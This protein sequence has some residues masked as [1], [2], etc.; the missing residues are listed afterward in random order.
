MIISGGFNIWPAE[1]ENA[2]ASHPAVLE[3]AAFGVP[4]P[5]WGESPKAVVVLR[6]GASASETELIAWCR[7]QIGPIKKPTSVEFRSDPLPMSAV[8]KP[9][10]RVLKAEYVSPGEESGGPPT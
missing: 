2:L 9:L 4:H 8:G 10:R 3:V 1:I 7:E 6:P 5:R